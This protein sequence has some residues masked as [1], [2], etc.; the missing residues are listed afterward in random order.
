[1]LAAPAVPG[2]VSLWRR[3][4]GRLPYIPGPSKPGPS[5]QRAH[6]GSSNPVP[7]TQE[8]QLPGITAAVVLFQSDTRWS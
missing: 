8:T 3:P 6:Y 7:H 4:W 2:A 1:M 5:G